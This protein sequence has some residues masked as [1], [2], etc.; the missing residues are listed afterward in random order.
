[1]NNPS[2]PG[3]G[4][5]HVSPRTRP[6]IF[7]VD[8][9]AAI[10][11]LVRRVCAP[12]EAQIQTFTS[13]RAFLSVVHDNVP[14]CLV[15][16][17]KLPDLNG[18]QILQQLQEREIELP[19]IFISGKAEVSTAVQAFKLGSMDFLEKPFDIQELH[20]TVKRA[21]ARDA[22]LRETRA[23]RT[24]IGD[25]IA[26]LTPR[27]SQVMEL[28]V[29]GRANKTIAAE[30]GVSP[31]T[32]E[33]HRANVMQKMQAGSLAEL[34]QMVMFHRSGQKSPEEQEQIAAH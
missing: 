20:D 17:Y 9:D 21:V 16:D 27:E 22:T 1:M 26:S 13:A 5:S 19:V 11:D 34:V 8:D 28:V 10:L 25:R 4:E 14:G 32:I 30:L 15:L 31:K 24:A 12:I 6:T 23:K 2:G 29:A 3:G 18:L 33:V 7:V